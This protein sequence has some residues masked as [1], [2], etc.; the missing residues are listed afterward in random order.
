M[1]NI[2]RRTASL[3][4]GF[5][6]PLGVCVMCTRMRAC[7]PLIQKIKHAYFCISPCLDTPVWRLC[8]LLQG[9][10]RP[11]WGRGRAGRKQ[12]LLR[13]VVSLLLGHQAAGLSAAAAAEPGA[14]QTRWGK[15][16]KSNQWLK[17]AKKQKKLQMC[18]VSIRNTDTKHEATASYIESFTMIS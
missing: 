18:N 6:T 1:W 3:T 11:G 2:S 4:D 16:L 17:S 8:S 13:L 12:Q 10:R 9:R 14:G 15:C 7:M 5:F